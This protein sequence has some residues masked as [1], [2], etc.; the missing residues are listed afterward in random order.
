MGPNFLVILL[1]IKVYLYL[2]IIGYIYTYI[3]VLS[4][5]PKFI[6]I[7][8]QIGKMLKDPQDFFRA[9]VSSLLK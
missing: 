8:S 4:L 2:Y 5:D 9:L 3:C 6:N 7:C 1:R